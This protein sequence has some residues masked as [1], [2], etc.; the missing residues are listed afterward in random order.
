MNNFENRRINS[1]T[2]SG[3]PNEELDSHIDRLNRALS[4][5]MQEIELTS[6]NSRVSSRISAFHP[7]TDPRAN[8]PSLYSDDLNL[9][10][11]FEQ[12]IEELL[13][14]IDR[15][16]MI[17]EDFISGE[18]RRETSALP[19]RPLQD[20]DYYEKE[21]TQRKQKNEQLEKE[22]KNFEE[23][24]S[25]LD[26]LKEEYMKKKEDVKNMFDKLN[27]KEKLLDVKEKEL[28][29][30]RMAF[31]RRKMIWEQEHGVKVED[32]DMPVIKSSKPATMNPLR[33]SLPSF[34]F[35]SALVLNASHGAAPPANENLDLLK[36][37]LKNKTL[38][39][40]K[41]KNMPDV[42]KSR[43]ELHIDQL[44]NKIATLRGEKVILMSNQTSRIFNNI[45]QTMQK[46]NLKEE[47]LGTKRK[48][49]IGKISAKNEP[50]ANNELVPKKDSG[51]KNE[52]GAKNESGVKNE[53]I[54]EF[55][56][57]QLEVKMPE[58]TEMKRRFL[59]SDA[60][61]PKNLNTPRTCEK[62]DPY[63]VYFDNK[64]KF[65][66]E[67]EKMLANKEQLLKDV[68]REILVKCPEAKDIIDR[69]KQNTRE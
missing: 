39:L 1:N 57:K 26:M 53:P 38:E 32:D 45:V 3:I 48:E 31:D 21:L 6:S 64:K 33:N 23:K 50:D 25:A 46:Q 24:L 12:K 59:F 18:Y 22:R 49:L 15:E 36:E 60:P 58:K 66:Q 14:T 34:S 65:I 2:L 44:K 27:E 20:L 8:S 13:L 5:A 54:E 11:E 61:T 55:K 63:K 29:A 41:L 47:E 16:Q 69:L 28:R 17:I 51:A 52:T 37:E 35:N 68:F 42:D 40:E 62:D 67:K 9:P 7:E 56:I 43:L 30:S 4:I 10:Y 19:L